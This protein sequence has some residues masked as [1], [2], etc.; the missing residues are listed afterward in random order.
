MAAMHYSSIKAHLKPYGIVARR[1]TTIHHAFAAAIA[2]HDD[3]VDEC[4]RH[5]VELLGQ[6]PDSDLRCVYCDA[7]AQT[8]DHVF[9]TVKST[10]LAI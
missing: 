7:M 5:A 2:P 4:V 1:A 8:W 3:Y 9:A 10:K 6:D